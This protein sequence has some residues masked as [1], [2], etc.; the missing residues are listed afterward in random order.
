MSLEENPKEE[1]ETI[2]KTNETEPK[3]LK[4]RKNRKDKVKPL[5]KVVFLQYFFILFKIKIKFRSVYC[6]F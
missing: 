3:Q 2:Q 1:S 5:A 6:L 4:D